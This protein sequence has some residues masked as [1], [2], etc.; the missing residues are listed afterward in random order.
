[1]AES[2]T[3]HIAS[4][5]VTADLAGTYAQLSTETLQRLGLAP[6]ALD[7]EQ[8]GERF[9]YLRADIAYLDG[10][11]GLVDVA[12]VTRTLL[13]ILDEREVPIYEQVDTSAIAAEGDLVRVHTDAG[14]F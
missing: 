10:S 7:S 8:I 9:P 13:R 5:S 1:M 14:E 2:V 4:R 12:S 11:G 6:E 3:R